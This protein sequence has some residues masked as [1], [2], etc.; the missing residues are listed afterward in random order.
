MCGYCLFERTVK[1]LCNILV[2]P[3]IYPS[4]PLRIPRFPGKIELF[5]PDGPGA[6]YRISGTP[7]LNDGTSGYNSTDRLSTKWIT[8]WEGV[9]KKPAED[10]RV[11]KPP[12]CP[13]PFKTNTLKIE[14]NTA[15]VRGWNE[16]DAVRIEGTET[17]PPFRFREANTEARP[18]RVRYR[19]HHGVHSMG[20]GAV[21]KFTYV[22]GDCHNEGEPARVEVA[23][24][25]P[26]TN[27][28]EPFA[29]QVI[30]VDLSNASV[31]SEP[32]QFNPYVTTPSTFRGK[33]LKKLTLG[34]TRW[35]DLQ[36]WGPEQGEQMNKY[37]WEGR[38][39]QNVEIV[40][41]ASVVFGKSR[42]N[43]DGGD[44]A[45][46]YFPPLTVVEKPTT[47]G[48]FSVDFRLGAA[49]EREFLPVDPDTD[50]GKA[51]ESLKG[52]ADPNTGRSAKLLWQSNQAEYWIN[53]KTQN[54][55]LR[56]LIL[57]CP[58]YS[59]PLIGHYNGDVGEAGED[60]F[61]CHSCALFS[62]DT[63]SRN[64][65]HEFYTSN[66]T[67]GNG[68]RLP[69][70]LKPHPGDISCRV[71][72]ESATGATPMNAVDL[73]S[74]D[75]SCAQ[76]LPVQDHSRSSSFQ[77]GIYI[78]FNTLGLLLCLFLI[79]FVYRFR[80][81]RVIKRTKRLF[82]GFILAGSLLVNIST[83]T[84]VPRLPE[85]QAMANSV[86]AVRLWL[87]VISLSLVIGTLVMKTWQVYQ[88]LTTAKKSLMKTNKNQSILFNARW[89]ILMTGGSIV[90][91]IIWMVISPPEAREELVKAPFGQ[92]RY[93]TCHATSSD[94]QW[95]M[96]GLLIWQGVWVAWGAVLAFQTRKVAS[97]YNESLSIGMAIYNVLVVSVLG[98]ILEAVLGGATGAYPDSA[99]WVSP[100]FT[101]LH[102]TITLLFYFGPKVI[103]I[104]NS[105]KENRKHAENEATSMAEAAFNMTTT[106][107]EEVE[108]EEHDRRNR[109]LQVSRE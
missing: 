19:P 87:P 2:H 44:I 91:L 109:V 64:P 37:T 56:A 5:E 35:L 57:T 61:T 76:T 98:L 45:D 63:Y 90:Y 14:L 70:I 50:T 34:L 25:E 40:K 26:L 47:E 22:V 8:L 68:R 78:V 48:P 1:D 82:A 49:A 51:A 38:A 85:D 108:L 39:R 74:Y 71:M 21:D 103:E 3:H 88:V 77:I 80:V 55:S 107:N 59:F 58:V 67:E 84:F 20:G 53:L 12:M 65:D 97:D 96:P 4:S 89:V 43:N 100:T 24:A 31:V 104:K 15:K 93:W 60:H 105:A 18:A 69:C 42:Y 13:K 92:I 16:L 102:T 41:R 75:V 33:T 95:L 94:V 46:S 36:F 6:I 9:A 29:V 28:G 83:F 99:T 62:K 32:R 27:F 72:D 23:I 54:T 17:Y 81:S 30:N 79:G 73:L 86:C 66:A 10:A 52:I 7:T 106:N 11:F 101:V